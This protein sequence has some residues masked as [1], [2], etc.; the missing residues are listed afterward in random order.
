MTNKA[1]LLVSTLITA[2]VLT[3]V[4]GLITLSGKQQSLQSAAAT[5]SAFV[6]S[7]RETEYRNLINQANQTIDQANNQILALESQLQDQQ[8]GTSTE[9]AYPITTAQAEQIADSLVGLKASETPRLVNYSGAAAYEVTFASG[10]VY[11]DANTGS[12]LYNSITVVQTITAQQAVAVAENY[13]GSTA[14]SGIN[15]GYYGNTGVY[16]IY[17]Q[18]GYVVYVDVYGNIL[19]VQSTSNSQS[20]SSSE[21]END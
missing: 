1:T 12:V 8:G 2:S 13:L 16:Q 21:T 3:L 6:Q 4:G 11:V 14:V 19:T 17:F 7:N 15:T 18:N 9:V 10:K 20:E 5:Q